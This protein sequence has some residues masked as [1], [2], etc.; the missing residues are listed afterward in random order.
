MGSYYLTKTE[1]QQGSKIFEE[2]RQLA[3]KINDKELLARIQ[4]RSGL[5]YSEMGNNEKA[6]SNLFAALKY[7]ESNNI[8]K[9]LP[10]IYTNIGL[11]YFEQG[12]FDKAKLYN[13]K[14]LDISKK[15]NNISYMMRAYNNLGIIY[16]REKKFPEALINGYLTIFVEVVGGDTDNGKKRVF[17]K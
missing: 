17:N 3:E 14:V 7:Y 5:C 6:F 15:E 4:E 11:L 8:V 9:S 2:A 1:N 12:L 10:S 16:S 13:E